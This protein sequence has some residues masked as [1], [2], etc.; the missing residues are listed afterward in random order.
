M[1]GL[2][3]LTQNLATMLCL[4][5]NVHKFLHKPN[6][7]HAAN[8][9]VQIMVEQKNDM[10]LL[11][12]ATTL[13]KSIHWLSYKTLCYAATQTCHKTCICCPIQ[14]KKSVQNCSMQSSPTCII[15]TTKLH[16][17]GKRKLCGKSIKA[18]GKNSS[19]QLILFPS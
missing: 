10:L 18:V 8:Y 4:W 16:Q 6:L 1:L 17:N 9:V 14:S 2:F 15:T 13:Q 11:C 7:F 3:P 19:K 5:Y 12:I